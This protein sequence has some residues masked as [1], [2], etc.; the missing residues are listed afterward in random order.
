MGAD[1]WM[2]FFIFDATGI[3]CGGHSDLL[4]QPCVL[5]Q[6]RLHIATNTA[7]LTLFK[8]TFV[9]LRKERHHVLTQ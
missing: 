7:Y 6:Q 2:A 9:K 1:G 5:T 3:D 8:E 4:H